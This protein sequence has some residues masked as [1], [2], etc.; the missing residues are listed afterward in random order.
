MTPADKA[1]EEA[2]HFEA[3]KTAYRQTKDGIALTIVLHPHDV[4]PSLA[5]SPLGTRYQVAMVEIDDTDQPVSRDPLTGAES[6]PRPAGTPPIART[7]GEGANLHPLVRRAVMLAKDERYHQWLQR[8]EY[9]YLTVDEEIAK[10]HIRL[11]C[12]VESRRQI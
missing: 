9:P 6:R 5:V 3:V 7:P 11:V 8:T 12:E 1:R 10:K 2:V 4:P